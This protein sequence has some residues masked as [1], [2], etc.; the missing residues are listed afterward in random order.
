MWMA[1]SSG[2][3][4]FLARA[5]PDHRDRKKAVYC[6]G[7]FVA[8][9]SSMR[10][11][12]CCNPCCIRMSHVIPRGYIG[13]TSSNKMFERCPPH[14]DR[15]RTQSTP[16]SPKDQMQDRYIGCS[17]GASDIRQRQGGNI[18]V[19]WFM[20]QKTPVKPATEEKQDSTIMT[21]PPAEALWPLL[22]KT[23][24]SFREG[25]RIK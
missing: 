8:N 11:K 2:G 13:Q 3:H 17:Q 10:Q 4:T 6:F 1:D 14:N 5:V 15:V 22:T 21:C 7:N 12:A 16:V 19:Q 9:I 18:E 23:I 20:M 25:V 24:R